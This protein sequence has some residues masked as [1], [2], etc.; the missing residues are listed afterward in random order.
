ME[1]ARGRLFAISVDIFFCCLKLLFHELCPLSLSLSVSTLNSDDLADLQATC[2][3]T[4][5][6]NEKKK[7]PGGNKNLC[8]F[9]DIA[10]A[11]ERHFHLSQSRR[12]YHNFGALLKMKTCEHLQL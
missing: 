12:K 7:Q 5:P 3:S 1:F 2:D 8:K 9:C 6:D 4:Y 11:L 10:F